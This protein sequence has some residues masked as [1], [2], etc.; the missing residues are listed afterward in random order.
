MDNFKGKIMEATVQT[1]QE[2]SDENK[3]QLEF[4]KYDFANLF[5]IVS[6]G[7][8]SYFNICNT[9]NFENITKIPASM[10]TLYE[11]KAGDTWTLISYNMFRTTKLWWL[12]CKFNGVVDPFTELVPGSSIR[13]PGDK[14]LDEVLQILNNSNI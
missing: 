2:F 5:K 6:K 13:I 12:L 1:I 10:L 14:I 9:I 8:K 4:S 3:L 11:V 7:E